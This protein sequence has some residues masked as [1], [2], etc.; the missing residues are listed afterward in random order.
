MD[1]TLLIDAPRNVLNPVKKHFLMMACWEEEALPSIVLLPKYQSLI[2]KMAQDS[3]SWIL[4]LETLDRI[5]ND[6]PQDKIPGS[7]KDVQ[8][9]INDLTFLVELGRTIVYQTRTILYQK[10][11]FLPQ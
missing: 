1:Y 10:K 7:F 5:I 11:S 6:A 8:P 3:P 4:Y 9:W 2:Q